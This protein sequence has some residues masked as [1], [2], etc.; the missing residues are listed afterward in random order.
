M[1]DKS[2]DWRDFI[3]V[4]LSKCFETS[5]PKISRINSLFVLYLST[6]SLICEIMSISG[7]LRKSLQNLDTC[8]F[9]RTLSLLYSLAR[10][11]FFLT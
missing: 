6:G 8:I 4:R 7:N 10:S 5:V 11:L 3:L 9:S 2:F 1:V